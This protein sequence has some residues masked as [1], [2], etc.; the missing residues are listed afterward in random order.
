MKAQ[1][2]IDPR[3]T[4]AISYCKGHNYFINLH[5][6]CVD[7]RRQGYRVACPD[8][9]SVGPWKKT[10]KAAINAWN[11]SYGVCEPLSLFSNDKRNS[12]ERGAWLCKEILGDECREVH[13]IMEGV[14]KPRRRVKV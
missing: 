14:R 7:G 1:G 9:G 3:K 5:P 2:G 8:C 4:P 11:L 13:E 10:P 12:I 6:T